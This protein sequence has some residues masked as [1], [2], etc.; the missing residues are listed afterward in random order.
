ML[1]ISLHAIS[2]M[3]PAYFYVPMW[4]FLSGSTI[5]LNKYIF[6]VCEFR[7]PVLLSM[8][9]MAFCAVGIRVLCWNNLEQLEQKR[10]GTATVAR[11][12]PIAVLFAAS[13]SCSNAAYMFLSVAYIQML[14]GLSV[15]VAYFIACSCGLDRLHVSDV[16]FLSIVC[17][18]VAVASVGTLSFSI[19][20]FLLQIVAVVCESGRVVLAQRFMQLGASK[21]TSVDMMYYVSPIAC[22]FLALVFVVIELPDF[23]GSQHTLPF[24]VLV[25]NLFVVFALNLTSYKVLEHTSAVAMGLFAIAKDWGLLV[26]SSTLFASYVTDTQIMG[27]LIA[28][29]GV[30]LYDEYRSSSKNA[31]NARDTHDKDDDCEI[32]LPVLHFDKHVA[33]CGGGLSSATRDSV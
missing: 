5:L 28:F 10:N 7:F 11:A 1:G 26:V 9:H 15:M 24:G 14:K 17:I 30:I 6:S 4:I 16:G 21:M 8:L 19:T 2:S 31:L 29:D 3:H 23:I 13:L 27:Y 22:A 20:G 18:G 12:V 32:Q 33:T 25:V